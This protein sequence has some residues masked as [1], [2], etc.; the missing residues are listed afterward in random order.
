MVELVICNNDGMAEGAIS[1]LASSGYN[2]GAEGATT[3]PVFGVDATSAAQELIKSGKMAG[4]I[5]QDAEGMATAILKCVQNATA[6][7]K[8]LDGM[9]EYN[10][11]SDVAKVRI[12]YAVYLGDK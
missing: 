9:E 4:T 5:K 1:A 3:I 8:L 10:I 11:D 2:T 6:E 12:A 7:K